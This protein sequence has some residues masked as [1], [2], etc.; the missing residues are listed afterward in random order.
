[1]PWEAEELRETPP[2]LANAITKAGLYQMYLPRSADG[3]EMS[4]LAAFSAIEELSKADGSVGWNVMN[5]TV[6]SFFMGW[7]TPN[8]A[9]GMCGDP[10]DL[11]MAGSLHGHG[12]RKAGNHDGGHAKGS[13]DVGSRGRR[14]H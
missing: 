7:L 9:R 4:H 2:A 1:M 5:A 10:A 14:D 12:W 11:R 6:L 8:V 3:P 13:G